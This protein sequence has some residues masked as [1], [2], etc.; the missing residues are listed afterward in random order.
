M[1][2]DIFLK[3]KIKAGNGIGLPPWELNIFKN[4]VC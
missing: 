1:A 4:S 2:M 3:V